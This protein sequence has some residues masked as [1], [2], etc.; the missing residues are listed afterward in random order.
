MATS[1]ERREQIV[2]Q[3]RGGRTDDPTDPADPADPADPPA[4][5]RAAGLRVTGVRLAV[6]EAL[7]ATPHADTESVIHTVRE[8]LGSVS[9]QAVY[10][11]V[12]AFTSRRIARRIQPASSPARYE[13]RVGD[14][15]HHAVCRTCGLTS[16][17]DC[18]VGRSPCLEAPDVAG[19][20]IDE[21]EVIFWGVC[22][23]CRS[24]SGEEAA[25]GS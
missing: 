10:N 15:H 20:Q 24:H 4:V 5:L 12:G 23:R 17:V 14:N 16:D 25:A 13:L 19:Y 1:I 2:E 9:D 21:A 3:A 8:Q 22:Q 18:A 11:V 6:L 7:R